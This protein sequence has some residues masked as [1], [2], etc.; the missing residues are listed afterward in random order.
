MTGF[1]QRTR[2]RCH[3]MVFPVPGFPIR[4]TLVARQELTAQQLGIARVAARHSGSCRGLR[5]FYLSALRNREQPRDAPVGPVVGFLGDQFRD[6][7]RGSILRRRHARRVRDIVPR[8]TGDAVA[9]RRNSNVS[10][11]RSLWR[12]MRTRRG[13]RTHSRS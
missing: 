7:E 6:I 2:Q 5:S 13:V 8:M 9:F 3:N 12:S 1:Q 11:V 4:Q 10:R